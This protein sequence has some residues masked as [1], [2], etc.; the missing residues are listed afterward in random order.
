MDNFAHLYPCTPGQFSHDN[1][2]C[3]SCD[4]T[5]HFDPG[6]LFVPQIEAVTATSTVTVTGSATG[7]SAETGTASSLPSVSSC[8]SHNGALI[9]VAVGLG[10]PLVLL[11]IG[12]LFA[13]VAE[14][15][16]RKA[17]EKIATQAQASGYD[18]RDLKGHS[19]GEK[20]QEAGSQTLHEI[21]HSHRS[22]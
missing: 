17:A 4:A 9:G 1:W 2:T 20:P 19:S 10:V 15:R 16:K 21:G 18:K 11:T 22:P 5:F 12:A 13:F 6:S 7:R 8:P 3:D 14:R